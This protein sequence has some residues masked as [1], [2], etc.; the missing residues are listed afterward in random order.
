MKFE[1]NYL[2]II[3]MENL[4]LKVQDLSL[5][6]FGGYKGVEAVSFVTNDSIAI[7][8]KKLS[9]K[10]SLLRCIANLEKYEGSIEL[11][12]KDI[13]FTFDLKSLKKSKSVS[14]NIAY[15]LII[16]KETNI[17]E[18]VLNIA[19]IFKIDSLLNKSIKELNISEQRLVILARAFV[20]EADLYLLDNPL[21]DVE[22]RKE[23]FEILKGL[24]KDKFVIYATD[25]TYEAESFNKILCMAYQKAIGFGTK[26]ELLSR[27]KT[28]DVLKLFTDYNFENIELKKDGDKYYIEYLNVRYDVKAPIS[29]IY[30]NKE[31]VFAIDGKK[32]ILD[33]YFDK[34]TEYIISRA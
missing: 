8:G 5:K 13:V 28:I 17:D 3:W 9:G 1:P 25:N 34:S 7:L 24:M 32:L 2:I 21:L 22:N 4:V 18:R 11:N 14:Y 6:Y 16:R 29:E 33:M 10:T 23:Y 19:K 26:D 31:V 30:D 20:R 12:A 15:P 27:P